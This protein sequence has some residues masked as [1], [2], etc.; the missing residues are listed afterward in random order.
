MGHRNRSPDLWSNLGG[1]TLL[2]LM[3]ALVL[4]GLLLALSRPAVDG[5]TAGWRLRAAAHQVTAVVQ[6]AQNAAVVK[7][8]PVQVLYDVPDGSFW[9]RVGDR[10][11]AYHRL[12]ED[13]KFESVRFGGLDV[14]YDVAAVR[15]MP[16][17]TLDAHEVRLRGR[18]G[19]SI[20][21]TFDRL[22]GEVHF[23]EEAHAP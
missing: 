23:L 14:V 6:W 17:G 12:P 4:V 18:S 2:E 20:R 3:V 7:G 21:L 16:D 15:A 11:Y 19:A 8:A 10:T 13:V 5:L 9:V 22:T 1:L